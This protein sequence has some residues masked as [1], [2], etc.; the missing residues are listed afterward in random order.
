MFGD[1]GEVFDETALKGEDR[2]VVV[3]CCVCVGLEFGESIRLLLDEQA[4]AAA[5]Y[6]SSI[7]MT[8]WI[9]GVE[10]ETAPK[11]RRA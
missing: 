6:F 1:F 8:P 5:E 4:K 11:T 7:K 3:G 2:D 10:S 9:K